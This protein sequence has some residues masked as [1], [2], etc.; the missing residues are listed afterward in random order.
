[1][2][3][4]TNAIAPSAWTDRTWWLWV[5]V[6]ACAFHI[7]EEYAFDWPA[8]ARDHFHVARNYTDYFVV[9]GAFLLLGISGAMIA[10]R[11]VAYSLAFPALLFWNAI[12]HA[13]ASLWAKQLNPGTITALIL[14]AP[15]GIACFAAAH[16][17]RVLTRRRAVAALAFG[18]AIHLFPVLIV[19]L[20]PRLSY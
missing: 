7:V 11:F 10:W 6:A 3:V 13:V 1:M 2:D 18:A 4:Q 9:N 15:A 5:A 8:F 17:D 14:L 12:F 16:K 19:L 20:R